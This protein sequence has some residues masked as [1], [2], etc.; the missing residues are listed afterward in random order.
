M[1]FGNGTTFPADVMLY[2]MTCQKLTKQSVRNWDPIS[3]TF[4]TRWRKK[5][6][7]KKEKNETKYWQTTT[8]LADIYGNTQIKFGCVSINGVAT[9]SCVCV[10][11]RLHL[12][13]ISGAGQFTVNEQNYDCT[14]IKRRDGE[15]KIRMLA[16]YVRFQY[17]IA[18]W[19]WYVR[20][21]KTSDWLKCVA[22]IS[23]FSK[24]WNNKMEIECVNVRF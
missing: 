14:L 13:Y 24:F 10:F 17:K 23:S 8:N 11:V 7:K 18:I 6:V 9:I 1:L 15:R 12:A 19:K 21:F 4:Q 16:A 22:V 2:F 20:I 3:T 5:W